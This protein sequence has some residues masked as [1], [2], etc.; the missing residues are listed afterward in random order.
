[1]D[2]NINRTVHLKTQETTCEQKTKDYKRKND[3]CYKI[4]KIQPFDLHTLAHEILLKHHAALIPLQVKHYPFYDSKQVD[5][6]TANTNKSSI[7]F[8]PLATM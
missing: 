3:N 5:L 1:M 6:H 7:A 2:K 4:V 8:S